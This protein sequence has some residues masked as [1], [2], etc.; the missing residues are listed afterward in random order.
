MFA[1]VT[2]QGKQYRVEAGQKVSV[3]RLEGMVGDAVS[4]DTVLFKNDG[5]TSHIGTPTVK[6]AVVKATIIAQEKGDKLEVRRYKQ[7]VRYRKTTGFRPLQT[8]LE[9]VSIS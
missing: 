2:I 7:K 9:I 6:G 5:K 1:I 8:K 3:D 4:F